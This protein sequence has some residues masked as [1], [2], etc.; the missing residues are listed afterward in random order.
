MNEGSQLLNLKLHCSERARRIKWPSPRQIGFMDRVYD[1][2][3]RFPDGSLM[4]RHCI[5]GL[6]A[7]KKTLQGFALESENEFYAMHTPTNEI[8]ARVNIGGA[9]G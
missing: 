6:E 8:V 5:T 3:E 4:W 2:F 1:I 9:R 7:A